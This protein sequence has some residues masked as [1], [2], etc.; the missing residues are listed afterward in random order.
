MRVLLQKDLSWVELLTKTSVRQR[1]KNWRST[2]LDKELL[3]GCTL[4]FHREMGHTWKTAVSV[5]HEK[6]HLQ[7]ILFARMLSEAL[8][9]CPR[10]AMLCRAK[11]DDDGTLQDSTT[12]AKVQQI[13]SVDQHNKP[14]GCSGRCD[15]WCSGSRTAI[16]SLA[17]L[18]SP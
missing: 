6:N 8:K 7:R 9:N 17:S 15:P 12:L 11:W 1:L 10:L 14:H 4:W 3:D 5:R 2:C 18:P 16:A 13:D